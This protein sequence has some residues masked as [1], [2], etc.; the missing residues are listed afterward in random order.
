[1]LRRL[2]SDV[3]RNVR[4]GGPNVV[5]ELLS[6]TYYTYAV[7]TDGTSVFS[8]DWDLLIVLDA[9]R[10]DL[11]NEVAAEHR[12]FGQADS[13]TSVGA[14]STEWL[15]D[16]FHGLPDT[17]LENT[18]YVTGNP[19]TDEYLDGD[20]FGRLDEV[21]R[22]AWDDD[23]G[24]IPAAPL[25]DRAIA[26]G[27][28]GD[29]D[30]LI[31]HYMQP[32]FPCVPRPAAVDGIELDRFGDR[33]LSI[34]EELRFGERDVD[35]AWALYRENL[36][37]VLDE[38]ADLLRNV[39]AETAVVTADHGNAFGEY[40]L[41]GHVSGVSIPPVREVP[42]YVTAATDEGTR[43]PDEYAAANDSSDSGTGADATDSVDV[44]ARL[45]ALGYDEE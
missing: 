20:R 30:R 10:A 11:W 22:Y 27:R 40:G 43:T 28:Q 15:T 24:T 16:T 44:A 7:S 26:A 8:A 2:A 32:H 19:Y 21:W 9:C 4:R 42:Q 17:A 37:Y 5:R 3:W 45:R 39:D 13:L 12:A 38:V 35:D 34:W 14:S 41:Y 1:M 6:R 33:P 31:V 23:L 25:T 29:F 36:R 18:A